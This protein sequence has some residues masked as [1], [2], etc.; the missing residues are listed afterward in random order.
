[1]RCLRIL[2]DHGVPRGLAGFLPGHDVIETRAM[3]WERFA[4]GALLNAA[5]EAGFELFVTTDQNLSYQQNLSE[6]VIAIVVLTGSS[7]WLRVRAEVGRIA[8]AVDGM[9][10]GGYVEVFIPF[11]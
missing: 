9:E 8:A 3:G 6:R 11:R 10:P 5:E 1:M 2:F 4:N 7:K